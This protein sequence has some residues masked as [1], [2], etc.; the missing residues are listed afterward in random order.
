[1][2]TITKEI[3]PGTGL[4][5]LRFGLGR[6]QVK[7]VLGEPDEIEQFEDEESEEV[8]NEAWHYD[9][10]ELSLSFDAEE[11]WKLSTISVSND[12][13]TLNGTVIVG[14]LQEDLTK[15]LDD[16]EMNYEIEEW[17][18]ESDEDIQIVVSAPERSINFWFTEGKVSEVQWGP[19]YTADDETIW[20]S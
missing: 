20:P 5:N 3:L 10:V 9:E 2:T 15:I 12:Q 11:D 17:N 1:M 6:D 7:A 19:L 18:N 8:I 4:D 16:Q 14:M 13:F